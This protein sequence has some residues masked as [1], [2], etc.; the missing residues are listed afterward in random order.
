MRW[1]LKKAI[2]KSKHR[3]GAMSDLINSFRL[4]N[5]TFRINKQNYSKHSHRISVVGKL[6]FQ[7][8]THS[9]HAC[10][11]D[12]KFP[13]TLKPTSA[14]R[15]ESRLAPRHWWCPTEHSLK[16]WRRKLAN[17]NCFSMN[18]TDDSRAFK[19]NQPL[20]KIADALKPDK[21]YFCTA[22]WTT[23]LFVSVLAFLH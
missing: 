18:K 3:S 14:D 20:I 19:T 17:G 10:R 13:V 22:F 11:L 1:T 16:T 15:W 6:I 7:V 23:Q 21:T 12:V 4:T 2:Y 8:D 9:R 5:R